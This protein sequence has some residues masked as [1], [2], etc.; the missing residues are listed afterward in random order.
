MP[1]KSPHART[2]K[3]SSIIYVGNLEGEGS[4]VPKICHLIEVNKFRYGEGEG[5]VSKKRKKGPT[6][7]MNES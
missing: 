5:G 2:S 4:K 1:M 6:S 3:G 7:F